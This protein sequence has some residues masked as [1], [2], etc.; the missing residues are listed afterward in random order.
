MPAHAVTVDLARREDAAKILEINR[1][2]YGKEDILVTLEDYLWRHEQN[3]T[4]QS[5]VPVLRNEIGEVV[6]FISL[7]PL[8]MRIKGQDYLGA[9]G[10]NLVIHPD[11]QDGFGYIKLLRRFNRIFKDEQIPLH[12]SFI[13]EDIYQEIHTRTTNLR[14][15]LQWVYYWL[16]YQQSIDLQSY[17]N[18]FAWTVPLLAKPFNFAKIAQ[19]Y[20]AKAWPRFI[21]S[22]ANRLGA[23]VFTQPH[24]VID[25]EITVQELEQIDERFDEFWLQ[26]QNKYPVMLNRGQAFL[27]WRFTS[28]SGR[29]YYFLG[30]YS[31][32]G[33][34]LGYLVL[35]RAIVRKIKAGLIMDFLVADNDLGQKAGMQLIAQAEKF[36]RKQHLAIAFSLMPSFTTEYRLLR[37]A[38]YLNVP[39]SFTPRPFRFA[40]FLHNKYGSNL[41]KISAKDWFITFADY[42]SF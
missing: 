9:T 1:L 35:R 27:K 15:F 40:F 31:K 8:Q 12:Y 39:D 34:M 7:I 17:S 29:H 32:T 26:N 23:V 41:P 42:E 21:R 37:R 5:I 14:S 2:E 11:Y 4:C 30:A 20:L 13:S 36:F 19:T 25:P 16:P 6:G 38:G 10:T 18:Q 28:L 3:P 24:A 33:Q 22:S